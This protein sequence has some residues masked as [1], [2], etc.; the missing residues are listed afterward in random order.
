MLNFISFSLH[1][2]CCCCCWYMLCHNS[3]CLFRVSDCHRVCALC[4]FCFECVHSHCRPSPPT[5]MISNLLCSTYRLLNLRFRFVASAI[6][7]QYSHS[8]F[9]RCVF[10]E[11]AICFHVRKLQNKH[12]EYDVPFCCCFNFG[13]SCALLVTLCSSTHTPYT[14]RTVR[15]FEF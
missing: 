11:F 10:D 1:C 9:S 4:D 5:Q 15:T 8:L 13:M 6:S 3:V 14:R 12:N 2:C 7:A